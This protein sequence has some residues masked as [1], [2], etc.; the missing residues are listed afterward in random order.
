MPFQIATFRQYIST[1]NAHYSRFKTSSLSPLETFLAGWNGVVTPAAT[2]QIQ[3][4]WGAMPHA[5]QLKYAGAMSYLR[6]FVNGIVDATPVSPAMSFDEF[7]VLLMPF[8]GHQQ[9]PM[10][11]YHKHSLT[12]QSS[13]GSLASLANIGTRERVTHRSNP[14][15]PPFHAGVNA[16]IPLQFT[17]GATSPTG[18]QS[19]RNGDDHSVGNPAVILRYPL[20]VGSVIADQVYEYTADMVNWH[21][22]PDAVYEIEKGV[23]MN[24]TN[25]VFFFRKQSAPPH[26]NRFHF[27]VEYAIGPQPNTAVQRVPVIPAGFASQAN[28]NDYASTVVR[29]G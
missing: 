11:Y 18:A 20:A 24:G 7:R 25:L 22:I 4:L 6:Q 27:E 13:N 1:A 12:W 23:R 2:A 17:Q 9:F 3:A 19:G 29:L 10:R 14:T 15:D 16:G 21:P 28:L 26:A 5:K 8:D